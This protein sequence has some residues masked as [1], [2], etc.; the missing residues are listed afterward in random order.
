MEASGCRVLSVRVSIISA[1]TD[2]VFFTEGWHCK[3][4]KTLSIQTRGLLHYVASQTWQKGGGVIFFVL[5]QSMN[6]P[7]PVFKRRAIA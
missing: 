2:T 3:Q 1:T 7:F 4:F 5:V 6:T